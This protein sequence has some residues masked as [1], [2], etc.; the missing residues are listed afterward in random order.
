MDILEYPSNV[1]L[2]FSRNFN[3]VCPEGNGLETNHLALDR[4]WLGRHIS[5]VLFFIFFC[6]LDVK[7]CTL[8]FA[9]DVTP[10]PCMQT[11]GWLI[12]LM[13]RPQTRG[14]I[15]RHLPIDVNH[16]DGS[17]LFTTIPVS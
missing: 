6:V 13:V 5:L 14:T 9:N 15:R 2:G 11:R 7:S 4:E 8:K 10:D 17:V 1:E 3:F 16:S 12:G